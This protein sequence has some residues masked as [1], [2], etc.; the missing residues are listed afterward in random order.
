MIFLYP[1]DVLDGDQTMTRRLVRPGDELLP[2]TLKNGDVTVAV[3]SKSGRA[4]WIIGRTYSVQPGRGQK[5][6]GRI[7]LLDIRKERLWCISEDDAAASGFTPRL[8]ATCDGFG[9]VGQVNPEP[10]PVCGG[11]GILDAVDTFINTWDSLHHKP[12][13][14][15]RDNPEVYV[16]KLRPV[17]RY[18]E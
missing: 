4:K 12:G 13:E 2:Y 17:E 1:D 5:A 11:H 8:C 9:S 16:L 14:R 7:R 6:I 10:C 18:D 3:Y 15:W